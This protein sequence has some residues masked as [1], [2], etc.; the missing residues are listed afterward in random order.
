MID[1]NTTTNR[2]QRPTKT[3]RRRLSYTNKMN[4]RHR[5]KFLHSLGFEKPIQRPSPPDRTIID[6]DSIRRCDGENNLLDACNTFRQSLNDKNIN[7]QWPMILEMSM[8]SSGK[9]R[10]HNRKIR[11]DN[12]VIVKHIPSHKLYSDRIRSTLWSDRRE[13]NKNAQRNQ[14]EFV[15]ENQNWESVLEEDDMYV[16]AETG[17]LIHPYWV[18]QCD[19]DNNNM[20]FQ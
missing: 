7:Y 6:Y 18:E 10:R 19:D 1:T 20:L 2:K 11:F 14:R 17:E 13:I 4:D 3:I 5:S 12:D 15:F 8:T 9:R 16:D